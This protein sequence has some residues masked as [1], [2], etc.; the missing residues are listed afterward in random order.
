MGLIRGSAGVAEA[1]GC[2]VEAVASAS[3]EN[4]A[5]FYGLDSI[6]G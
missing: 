3:W 1:K 4:A 6:L 5:R 2:T